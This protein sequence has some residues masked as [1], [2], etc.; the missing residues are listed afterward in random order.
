[1]GRRRRAP[2]RPQPTAAAE[3]AGWDDE[4]APFDREELER[5]SIRGGGSGTRKPELK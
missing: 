2:R 3:P 4:H 1:V 5:Y